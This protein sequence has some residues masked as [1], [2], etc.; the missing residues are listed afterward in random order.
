MFLVVSVVSFITASEVTQP[1]VSEKQSLKS[2]SDRQVGLSKRGLDTKEVFDPVDHKI[3]S[4]KE[5]V[6]DQ[7]SKKEQD[8]YIKSSKTSS[9]THLQKLVEKKELEN[10]R[11]VELGT[12][13][14]KAELLSIENPFQQNQQNQQSSLTRNHTATDL[15]FSEYSEGSSNHKYVE[16]YNPTGQPVDLS[17]YRIATTSNDNTGFERFTDLP[18]TGAVLAPGDVWVLAH[19]ASDTA[20]TNVADSTHT[21]FFNGDDCWC[22]VTGGTWTDT[23]NDGF[24]K[25]R[26]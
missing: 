13:E 15:F 7:T 14:Q 11:I 17:D 12:K 3:I 24:F 26:R 10:K 8:E 22:L 19:S 1:A 25:W 16:I 9:D 6:F 5:Q 4:T 21:F 2:V 20:I 18:E 23:D